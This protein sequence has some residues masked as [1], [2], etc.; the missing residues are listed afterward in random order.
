MK[1]RIAGVALA[2]ALLTLNGCSTPTQSSA[3]RFTHM[4]MALATGNHGK[5]ADTRLEFSIAPDDGGAAVA[6]L[7]LPGQAL[8][9]DSRVSE[10]VL[11]A[12]TG[13]TLDQL[14]HEEIVVKITPANRALWNLGFDVILHFDDGSQA[15]LGSGDLTLSNGRT[16]AV[17]PLSEATVA[18]ASALGGVEKFAFKLLSKGGVPSTGD[19]PGP[20]TASRPHGSAKE[21][22]HMDLALATGGRGKDADTRVE[23]VIAPKEG[24]PAVAYLDVQGQELAAD[25]TVSEVVPAAGASFTLSDLK[26]E[27][28]FVRITP[29]SGRTWTFGFDAIL[30]F[31]DGTEAL[32][33]TGKLALSGSNREVLIPLSGV[34][35]AKPTTIGGMEKFA[36][37]LLSKGS[38]TQTAP[39][40]PPPPPPGTPPPPGDG[41]AAPVAYA[42]TPAPVTHLSR[43]ATALDFTHMDLTVKTRSHGK[44]EETR[45]EFSIVPRDGGAPAA[46]LDVRGQAF[47][48][49]STAHEVVPAV[50]AGFTLDQLKHEQIL[51]KISPSVRTTWSHSFDIVLHFAD[52]SE[53]FWSTDKLVLT[54]AS[55]QEII[56]LADAD[57]A[58]HSVLGGMKKFGFGL[59]NKVG[60]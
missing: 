51:V 49:G 44:E 2:T 41:T 52:G 53:A 46:Y 37:R 3:P 27:Q 8:A 35:I 54:D 43:P 9:S 39:P 16:Q 11:P 17:V 15:L 25:T 29:G 14:K 50:G 36:F 28:I 33:S 34:T 4:D 40:A 57:V 60:K 55:N 59:L 24:D 18:S 21:F 6:Y 13:F 47:A 1:M 26:H 48:P 10:T 56:S 31:A 42:S 23:F 19:A 12:G 5:A 22:T 7:D 38:V 20:R 32:W 30:H 45:L 58:S